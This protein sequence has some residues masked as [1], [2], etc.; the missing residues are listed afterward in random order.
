MQLTDVLAQR[1][2]VRCFADRPIPDDVLRRVLAAGLSMPHGGNTYAWRGLVLREPA[3]THSRWAEMFDAMMRQAFLAEAPALVIWTMQP[4]LW[5][6]DYRANL[7][8]LVELELI[9]PDRA[10]TL[11]DRMSTVPDVD[12]VL[13]VLIGDAMMAVGA[14]M[15]AAVESGLGTA[16]STGDLRSLAAALELP[17]GVRIAP[18]GV[19]A[20]GYPR[21]DGTLRAPKPEPADL[22]YDGIWQ[23]PF[24]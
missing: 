14:V 11:L 1:R 9:E 3:K 21:D 4:R 22:F 16:L 7:E 2:T 12:G 19:L 8:K 15:L 6:E 23:A 13:P 5:V 17:R 24:R 18:A 10:G 20:L